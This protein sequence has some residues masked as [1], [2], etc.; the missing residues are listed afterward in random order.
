MS[1]SSFSNEYLENLLDLPEDRLYLGLGHLLLTEEAFEGDI[2][3]P[4]AVIDGI[5]RLQPE[6]I[7]SLIERGQQYV[8]SNR[9]ILRQKICIEWDYCSKRDN[10]ELSD[11]VTLIAWLADA[12]TTVLLHSPLVVATVAVILVKKGLTSFCECSK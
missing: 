12:L 10:A 1:K 6:S 5:Y 9:E 8:A 3:E 2:T 4:E 11:N 7:L